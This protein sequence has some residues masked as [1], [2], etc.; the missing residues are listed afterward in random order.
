[1]EASEGIS[2][3]PL[4]ISHCQHCILNNITKKK[5]AYKKK[6]IRKEGVNLSVVLLRKKKGTQCQRLFVVAINWV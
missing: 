4:A 1:V 2:P 6:N 5:N 3:K